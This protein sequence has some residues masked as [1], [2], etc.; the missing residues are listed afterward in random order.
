MFKTDKS[1]FAVVEVVRKE[2]KKTWNPQRAVCITLGEQ[3]ENHAGMEMN[4]DGLADRGYSLDDLRRIKTEFE[5]M[6]GVAELTELHEKIDVDVDEAGVLFLRNGVEVL[7]GDGAHKKMFDELTGFEWD[8][9]FWDTRRQKVLCKRARYNVCFGDKGVVADFENKKG[10]I[11]GYDSVPLTKTW[12]EK[13]EKL[14]N[15][16]KPLQAEGN[17][18]YTMSKCYIGFHGD[19]ERKRVVACNVGADRVIHWQWYCE[20]QRCGDRIKFDLRGG[21]VYLMSEKAS[22][23]DW[24]R[25]KMYTL[26]HAAAHT[27]DS[28]FLK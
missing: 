11:I 16:Q 1:G 17:Y 25:R 3:S 2:V 6:G 4:G 24:K 19:G 9:K 8:T 26:R 20:S 5:G 22:G 28:K 7:L 12:K 15:E 10:T 13:M 18:Y 14:C 23:W 21:D 27:H